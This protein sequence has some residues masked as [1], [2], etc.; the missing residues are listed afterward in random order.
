M[1]ISSFV[2]LPRPDNFH[3]KMLCCRTFTVASKVGTLRAQ[4]HVQQQLFI[5]NVQSSGNTTTAIPANVTQRHESGISKNNVLLQR[6]LLEETV[7]S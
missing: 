6:E 2:F 1:Y 7:M 4:G 5:R 3:C